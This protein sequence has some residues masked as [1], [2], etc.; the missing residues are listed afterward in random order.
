[1][2][3]G[4]CPTCEK[5]PNL[6]RT[7]CGLCGKDRLT[8]RIEPE[9]AS[10]KVRGVWLCRGCLLSLAD[11]LIPLVSHERSQKDDE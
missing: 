2:A 11:R 1:M 7:E 8:V 6:G 9:N 5:H 4:R 3:E 10:G